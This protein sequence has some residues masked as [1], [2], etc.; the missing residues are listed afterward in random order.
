MAQLRISQLSAAQVAAVFGSE[1]FSQLTDG[2]VAALHHRAEQLKAQQQLAGARQRR[3][4][5]VAAAV[6]ALAIA[7]A[8]IWHV[9]LA[10]GLLALIWLAVIGWLW[11][12]GQQG[13]AAIAR[14]WGQ[15]GPQQ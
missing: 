14:R 1:Q 12:A 3:R 11:D 7:L 6:V 4:L 8:P 10:M 9:L 15:P 13:R 5:L 2:Q